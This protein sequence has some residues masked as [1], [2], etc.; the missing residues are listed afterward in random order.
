MPALGLSTHGVGLEVSSSPHMLMTS[1][2][3]SGLCG[4]G[5]HLC[6]RGSEPGAVASTA[7]PQ[8]NT[9]TQDQALG[10]PSHQKSL[11]IL[12]AM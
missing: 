5:D 4:R 1:M 8:G 12:H 6:C 3:D 10:A 9:A 11:E 2:G 7:A